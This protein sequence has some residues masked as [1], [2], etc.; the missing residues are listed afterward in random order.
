M[1][2]R[3][4]LRR[5]QKRSEAV[6]ALLGIG[7]DAPSPSPLLHSPAAELQLRLE[8]SARAGNGKCFPCTPKHNQNTGRNHYFLLIFSAFLVATGSL[9]C[10]HPHG[11]QQ[12]L[13][14]RSGKKNG[15]SVTCF[16]SC[17]SMVCCMLKIE[18]QLTCELSKHECNIQRHKAGHTA[19]IQLM[20]LWP[21][22]VLR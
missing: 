19:F 7:S 4:R 15:K 12:Q 5:R 16:T 20:S 1:A 22:Q 6:H 18:E 9:P 13:E 3:Q 17:L 11:K 2:G 14:E 8:L 21:S 10:E